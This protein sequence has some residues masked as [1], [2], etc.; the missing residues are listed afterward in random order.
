MSFDIEIMSE[1]K[2]S[3]LLDKITKIPDWQ[4]RNTQTAREVRRLRRNNE[5]IQNLQQTKHRRIRQVNKTQAKIKEDTDQHEN[6]SQNNKNNDL[7][8]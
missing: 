4:L 8:L 7:E 3:T 2:I 1:Q 6:S 5:F